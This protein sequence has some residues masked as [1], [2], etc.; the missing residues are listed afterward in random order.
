MKRTIACWLAALLAAGLG[1]QSG[2]ADDI[3]GPPAMLP[4]ALP[5]TPAAPTGAAPRPGPACADGCDAAQSGACGADCGACCPSCAPLCIP[6]CL[7][8]GKKIHVHFGGGCCDVEPLQ[9]VNCRLKGRVVDYTHNHGYDRRIWSRSLYQR[10]DLY[11]YLPPGYSDKERY[12]I[13]IFLHGFADDER[14]FLRLVPYLDYAIARGLMPP[15]I[16]VAPDG[17]LDGDGCPERP[18]SFFLNSHAG[19][20]EDFVLQ[21][22]WD[23]VCYHYPL[24]PEREAHVLAGVS[25]GGFAAYS[26]GMRHRN[27]FGVVIGVNPLLNLRWC[28]CEGNPCA[29]FDPRRWGWRQAFNHRELVSRRWGCTVRLGQVLRPVFGEGDEAIQ[30]MAM[31]NPI[32]LIDRTCL[33]N[34]QLAMYVG[35]G[36]KD[37]MVA[38]QVESF[39]YYAKHRH[40]G[41][42]VG[43][44]PK[45]RCNGKTAVEFLPPIVQWLAPRLAPFAPAP[46]S[47][48]QPCGSVTASVSSQPS[49]LP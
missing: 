16:A 43:Y 33:R 9:R 26:I 10:R 31:S 37:S 41:M 29:D 30:N 46:A 48:A 5:N 21:D 42:H 18:G 32:E 2:A 34:G 8:S 23:F 25:M 39:L 1:V 44:D 4:P 12:P 22:V 49:L 3:Q 40:L 24:R 20:Y 38:A 6:L 17:S 47:Y 11:V 7:P 13:I 45:G 27:A 15:V 19:P 36:G 35:Y 28:D 14:S